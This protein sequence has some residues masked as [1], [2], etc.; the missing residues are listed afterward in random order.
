MKGCLIIHGYTG[1]PYEVDPLARYLKEQTEWS[2][3]VP[4]LPGHGKR[5]NLENVTYEAWIETAEKALKQLQDECDEVYV[6]G[7]SMGGMIAAY[8]AATY[9]VDRLVLLSTAR[10]YICFKHLSSYI[11]EIIGDGFRGKLEENKLYA[12][13]KSKMGMVPFRANLE[14]M[15]LVN[16]TK[17][18]LNDVQSPV[19]IAQGQQDMIV[20]ASAAYYLD[21]EIGSE[22]KEVVLFEQSKH[23]IC[24]GND[25]KI[26]NKKI[27]TFLTQE[28][29]GDYI[30]EMASTISK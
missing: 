1:G 3:K 23:L 11:R 2:I 25:R 27:L 6:I 4:L 26:L 19:F 10:R 7:F 22:H 30:D 21:K 18:Y 12:H 17:Q 9:E 5:L 20:P 28:I 15:K 16:K 14:F 29:E 8:L 13:Y 24:L